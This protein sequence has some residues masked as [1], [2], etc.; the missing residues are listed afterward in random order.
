MIPYL[1]TFAATLLFTFIAQ[2]YFNKNL[3]G[4]GRLFSV[5]AILIPCVLAGI[6]AESVG[7]DVQV[8]AKP[9]F[10]TASHSSSFF[11]YLSYSACEPLYSLLVFFCAKVSDSI[12]IL[13]FAT[14]LLTILPVYLCAYIQRKKTSMTMTMMA[15]LFIYY[16]LSLSIMRQSVSMA[17]VLLVFTLYL[18]EHR[19]SKKMIPLIVTAGLFHYFA[20]LIVAVLFA[21]EVSISSRRSTLQKGLIIVV[22]M[23]VMV[24]IRYFTALFAN[25]FPEVFGKYASTLNRINYSG[26]SFTDTVMKFVFLVLCILPKYRVSKDDKKIIEKYTY[27]VI[28]GFVFQLTSYISEYLLRISYYFQ[29][30]MILPLGS[31]EKAFSRKDKYVVCIGTAIYTLIYWYIVYISWNWHGTY[32]YLLK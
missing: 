15:Y 16:N 1:F 27:M 17:I 20:F 13:L 6:R 5:V 31:I 10:L 2:Y 21:I 25:L 28:L 8:Y 11:Q 12:S 19:F 7:I 24:N 9:E 14:Q 3:K 4:K 30:F 29:F 32:P 23:Y 26:F 18:S 22:I